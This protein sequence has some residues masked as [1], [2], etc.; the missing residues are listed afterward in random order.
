MYFIPNHI[1]LLS[2]ISY[3]RPFSL[4]ESLSP[5]VFVTPH[6]YL[7]YRRFSFTNC[8][9]VSKNRLEELT[10]LKKAGILMVM[11]YYSKMNRLKSSKVKGAWRK[12]H[13]KAGTSSRCLLPVKLHALIL[14][15]VICDTFVKCYQTGKFTKALVYRVFAVG[16]SLSHR[17]GI[18]HLTDLSCL[19]SSPQRSN[20]YI[21]A[22]GLK[23]TK[24]GIQHK[25]HWFSQRN[26][27]WPKASGIPRTL[28]GQSIP[29]AQ[30]LSPRSQSRTNS[31]NKPFFWNGHGLSN[32]GLLS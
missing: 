11:V 6:S 24:T 1:C 8:V 3:L 17:Y 20:W 9:G 30:G 13:R 7:S 31:K 15:A 23:H 28:V 10:G 27:V 18:T 12:V 14:P 26:R 2:G 5:V 21:I 32:T 4:L 22:Q 25:S 16:K 29:R 19:N